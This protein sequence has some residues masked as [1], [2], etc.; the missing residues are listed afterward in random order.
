V[1]YTQSGASLA[2]DSLTRWRTQAAVHTARLEQAS[3]DYRGNGGAVAL[4]AQSQTALGAP[5]AMSALALT[6]VPGLYAYEDASQGQ[7]LA[8]RQMQALDAQR[9]QARAA[10]TLR[11]AA[12][13]TRITLAEHPLHQLGSADDEF[14]IL[15]AHHRARSN[16]RADHKA[17]VLSLL[18]AIAQDQR[19]HDPSASP[20]APE[21][22]VY[23]SALTLQPASVPVR[24]SAQDEHGRPAVRLHPRPTVHG[25]QTALV[26]GTG[27]PVHTDRDHRIKVQFHWPRGQNASHSMPHSVGSN[28]PP[29]DQS[30]TWV[31][32]AAAWA[33]AKRSA[34]APGPKQPRTTPSSGGRWCTPRYSKRVPFHRMGLPLSVMAVPWRGSW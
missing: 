24:L 10:G 3:Q 32:V 30:G 25:V 16:L 28:A 6:D 5:E 2:E 26:F 14:I 21:E 22:P 7:R 1:R 8:L 31:R 13:A 23:S 19:P 17:Q 27:A 9:Q 11:S 33:G 20:N 4:R 18:G 29:S 12:P 15:G 34:R